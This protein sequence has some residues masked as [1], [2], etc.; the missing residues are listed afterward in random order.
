MKRL[1]LLI[2]LNTI[3][4]TQGFS[5]VDSLD[6]RKLKMTVEELNDHTIKHL[7]ED[8]SRLQHDLE[9]AEKTIEQHDDLYQNCILFLSFLS[10]LGIGGWLWIKDKAKEKVEEVI[11]DK[12]TTL[13]KLFNDVMTERVIKETTKILVFTKDGTEHDQLKLLLEDNKFSNI[14]FKKFD[15]LHKIS[16][17]VF[18]LIIFVD[19]YDQKQQANEFNDFTENEIYK[20]VKMYGDGLKY[21]YFGSGRLNNSLMKSFEY[22]ISSSNF[23]S[24]VIGNIINLLKYN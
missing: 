11:K 3:S 18:N 7:K 17:N 21:F 16:P 14:S 22:K 4:F 10:T 8:V 24:Q 2:L 15:S 23:P 19:I 1:L 9:Q 12:S 13:S 20:V 5:K 6:Y